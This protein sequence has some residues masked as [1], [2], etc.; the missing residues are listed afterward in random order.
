MVERRSDGGTE[1]SFSSQPRRLLVSLAYLGL[2]S[3]GNLLI[4]GSPFP[5]LDADGVWFYSGAAFLL[6]GT[7]L[8]EPFYPTPSSA[9]GNSLA[10]L[11]AATAFPVDAGVPALGPSALELAK[12]VVAALA[13]VV[14]LVAFT[15]ILTKDSVGRYSSSLALPV[16]EVGSAR[17]VYSIIY[18]GSAFAT[19][20][21]EPGELLVLLVLWLVVA[22]V[23]PIERVTKWA[24]AH[25]RPSDSGTAGLVRRLIAPSLIDIEFLSGRPEPGTVLTTS[26]GTAIVL[27]VVPQGSGAW[28]LA[29]AEGALP[30]VG[31]EVMTSSERRGSDSLPIGPI[32]VRSNGLEIILRVPSTEDRL[33]LGRLVTCPVLGED[34][35]FQVV[36][37]EVASTS[38]G[39]DASYQ[40]LAVAAR[41]IGRWNSDDYRF[42]VA[43]WLPGPGSIARLLPTAS[44]D[45]TTGIGTLP[46]TG[47][48]VSLDPD[49]LV[50][51][52]CAVLGILGV[53]KSVLARQLTTR[54][55]AAGIKVVVLDITGE[56]SGAFD[57]FVEEQQEDV[58]AEWINRDLRETQTVSAKNRTLGGSERRFGELI[59]DVIQRFWDSESS[60]LVLNPEAF[61]VSRQVSFQDRDG[62][63]EFARLS[64]A[65]VTA[66]ISEGL[67]KLVRQMPLTHKARLMLVVEEAHALIPEWNSAV[68]KSDPEAV[69]T[70]AR[71]V[72]QGRKHGMGVMIISQRTANVTKTVLNQCHT[73]VAMRSYDSTGIEFL[74]NYMGSSYSRLLPTLPDR[75]MVA[76][77]RASSCPTPV[78]LQVHDDVRFREAVTLPLA[79]EASITGPYEL[80][81]AGEAG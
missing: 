78:V 74:S 42:E 15:V 27:D 35:L 71:A 45:G 59:G 8:Q 66:T 80:L 16:S 14:M 56:W 38:V 69:N 2:L 57:G 7:S 54:V 49:L 12:A 34:C 4:E 36:D 26:A 20:A 47:I 22:P 32:D 50:T 79:S 76:F 60:L 5:Q 3:L 73:I 81:P 77:G 75:Q 28:S 70:T 25:P 43:D 55:L 30:T 51:H 52:N 63:A 44:T 18:L 40:Y 13:A 46:E 6:I 37:V 48:S 24:R 33:R 31:S 17:V 62:N 19:R 29:A 41:K 64:P 11:V 58:V 61:V 65:D 68:N 9:A 21:G 72:L 10:L 23:R 53:G 67:L 39:D 1:L